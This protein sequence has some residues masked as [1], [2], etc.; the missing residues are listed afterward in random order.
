MGFSVELLENAIRAK[1]LHSV[2]DLCSLHILNIQQ[3]P[4]A[5]S[6]RLDA[7]RKV[8]TS[9]AMEHYPTL[10]SQNQQES[11]NENNV[12]QV[13]EDNESLAQGE[14]DNQREPHVSINTNG[15]VIEPP[16]QDPNE[17]STGN[18]GS[19][20]QEIES[21]SE[22]ISRRDKEKLLLELFGGDWLSVVTRLMEEKLTSE[23]R[24]LVIIKAI[25]ML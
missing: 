15:V 23:E 5:P 18:E 6:P 25:Q 4:I 19:N 9:Y 17:D 10:L 8:M 2:G 7:F 22:L 1:G 3:L 24:K 16:V 14:T 11:S 21:S 12:D 13:H 20:H